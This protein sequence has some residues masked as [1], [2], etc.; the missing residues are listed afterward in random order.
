MIS[1]ERLTS[2]RAAFPHLKNGHVYLNHAAFGVLSTEV[3]AHI[4]K[5]LTERSSG[6]IESYMIDQD[7]IEET[8]S[9]IAR[10]INAPSSDQIA[11]VTNTSEG[12]NLI[13]GGLNWQKGDS[14]LLNDIEFPSNVYPYMN[15][16]HRGVDI[17]FAKSK[18]GFVSADQLEHE[19]QNSDQL[20]GISAVQFLS[21]YRIDLHKL[22]QLCADSDKWLVV[23]GIQAAGSSPIDVQ[24]MQ[25]D[26][27][28]SG[29]LKW[30]MAPMGIGFVYF[31]EEMLN[32]LRPQHVGWLSVETPWDLFN[33][34]QGLN[35]TARRYELGGL[36]VPGIY[37]LHAS[38]DPF[39][40]LGV[41]EVHK[42]VVSLNQHIIEKMDIPG[43]KLYTT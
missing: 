39:L 19:I 1:E 29:G 34:E 31:S 38:L 26:A 20:V 12:L 17:R 11:F 6:V 10:L 7:I 42:H 18:Q 9:K 15:L 24:A 32:A 33:Y 8:R 22:G 40:E 21:G 4:N 14:I 43:V 36:N 16:Q 23:D 28:V 3:N 30:L 25:I 35:P 5:H 2:Y 41:D 13:A 27:F 37:A